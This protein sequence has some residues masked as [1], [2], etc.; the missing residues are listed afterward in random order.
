MLYARLQNCMI[1]FHLISDIIMDF[2]A[3]HQRIKA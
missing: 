2:N 1:T 3:T